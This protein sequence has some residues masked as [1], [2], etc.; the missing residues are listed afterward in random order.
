MMISKQRH[1]SSIGASSDCRQR[2]PI[3]PSSRRDNE[4]RSTWPEKAGA[5]AFA[6]LA[7]PGAAF[8]QAC[9]APPAVNNTQCVVAPATTLNVTSANA[10]GLNA[11]GPLGLIT[12]NGITVN[13]GAATTTGALAQSGST[14]QFNGSTL[15]TTATTTATSAGQIGL[16]ASGTGSTINANG[17]SITM[18]PPN[19]TTTASNMVGATAQAGGALNLT[20]MTLQTLG[21]VNGLTNHGLIA[22][23]TGSAITFSGGSVATRSRGSFGALAQA[24]GIITLGNG[25]TITTT[26]VQNTVGPVGSHGLIA[27]GAGSRI[28]GT[29]IT[30]NTSGLLASGARAELG[31]VVSLT[32]SSITSSSNASVDT[33]PSSAARALSGGILNLSGVTINA[34]GQRGVG[35]SVEDAGSTATI[36]NSTVTVS[37]TRAPAILI[38]NGGQATV[39]DSTLFSQNNHGVAVQDAGS[40]ISLTNSAIRSAGPVGY[41][42]RVVSGG[43][44]TVVGGSSTTEGRDGPALYAANGTITATDVTIR[45]SGTDN[46]MGVLADLNGQITLNGGSVTTTGDAVRLSSFP[47]GVAARNPN[48][49]LTSTGTT[50]LTTGIVAMGAVADDGG[51]VFL[52]GNTITTLGPGSL[53]LYA[54]VEQ[55]GAQFPATITAN[56]IIVETSGVAAHGAGANQHFLVAP[57]VITLNDSS[58]TTHG[59]LSD[60]LRAIMAATVNANRSDVLVEGVRSTGMHARDNGSSVNLDSTTILAT[61]TRGHGALAEAGGL[62]T[63]INST[64]EA[65]GT[66]ASALYVAGAP[67]FVSEARFTGSSL[68]NA[69]GPTIAVGGNGNVTLTTSTAGGSGEWLRVATIAD[70]PPLG[71]PDAGPGGITDPEGIEVPPVFAAPAALPV[72]PGLANITLTASTVTGSAFT[73]P[74]SVSNVVMRDDSVWNLTGSSNL[75]NLLND[76]SLIDFSP[77]VGDPTLLASYK[78]LTVVNYVGEDGQIALNTYLGT[79]G[80]PSDIL[81]VDGGTATGATS[82]IVRNTTGPGALTTANGILVVDTINGATSES[83]AFTLLGDYITDNGEQAVVGGAYAYTLNF[84]GVGAD[85][86]DNNW[87]LRSRLIPGPDPDPLYQP[88]VPIYEA[89]PQ[90][91]LALNGMPTMQQRVGNRYWREPEPEPAEIFCKD[92]S[93]NF[94]CTVTPEQAGYY[95]DGQTARATIEGNGVWGRLEGMHSQIEPDVTTSGT[96][97]DINSWKLQAGLDGLL[98]EADDGSKLIGGVTIHYGQASSDVSSIYGNG[99]IDTTGFGFGGTLTWLDQNGFYVDGQA[100]VTWY[101]SDLFSDTAGIGLAD[102]N[103]GIGYA[104]SIE[105]GKKIDLNSTWTITPQAQ[106]VYSHVDFDTFTDPF[107][108]SVSLDDGDSL[109][110]RLGISADRDQ[111]WKDDEGKT[112]RSH[113]YGIANLYYEF[114]DATQVDVSG[115]KFQSRPERLWGGIGAGGSYNWEDDKYSVYGEVSLNTSLANFADSYTVGGTIGFRVKW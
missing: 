112:R 23:G 5:L 78:T 52:N 50:I 96:D 4:D 77:P 42:L 105:T 54:T 68:T 20:N 6:S 49:V 109:R 114:L 110:G 11:A 107:D 92:P 37:G 111:T 40:T 98:H 102:G 43:S 53:G 15:A 44:A 58:V 27:T 2:T 113:L 59:E 83:T 51:S 31:G 71:I 64:V 74:G 97:Y 90:N 13:L 62:I 12:G 56:D 61:G 85:V 24:G 99:S 3:P 88:G 36:E 33:D 81:V 89:Y 39:T 17:A 84:G 103:N 75:T 69:S 91:L 80:A 28:T 18:G 38:F 60:G 70:F 106:L 14:I 95:A 94:R 87:Y 104:L 93:R 72:V 26:G 8:A 25:A 46:A 19:G 29:D 86:T 10:I 63:G 7:L 67:G 45:T 55:A 82:L 108:A 66:E 76:P 65:T 57:S 73:A 100:A 79:D 1:R 21:G 32:G 34:S 48:G 9:P 16:R 35:I 101:D 47:H 30:V 41:G 115:T 22:T